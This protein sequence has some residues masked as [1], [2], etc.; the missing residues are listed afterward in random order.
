MNT[1]VSKEYCIPDLTDTLVKAGYPD[2][3]VKTN[4]KAALYFIRY[5]EAV[6]NLLI[7]MNNQDP[8]ETKKCLTEYKTLVETMD[9]QFPNTIDIPDKRA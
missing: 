5:R 4:V 6:E 1:T 3:M 8:E 7:A 2:Y 9:N